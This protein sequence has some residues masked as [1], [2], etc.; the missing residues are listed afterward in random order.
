MNHIGVAAMGILV[1]LGVT[2]VEKYRIRDLRRAGAQCTGLLN[3]AQELTANNAASYRQML[4][5][6]AVALRANADAWAVVCPAITFPKLRAGCEQFR[7]NSNELALE[8]AA[9]K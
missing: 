7:D 1:A 2:S 6:E 9:I 4:V 5:Q 8:V 3:Q